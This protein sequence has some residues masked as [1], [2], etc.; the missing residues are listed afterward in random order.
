LII[1]FIRGGNHLV[2]D[3][4]LQCD[5]PHRLGSSPLSSS[6]SCIIFE[7]RYITR[8]YEASGALLAPAKSV[9]NP[10][11]LIPAGTNLQIVMGFP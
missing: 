3:K 6:R 7:A 11:F 8:V 9:S 2:R 10:L 1:L 5:P 4:P